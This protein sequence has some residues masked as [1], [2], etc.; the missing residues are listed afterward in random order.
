MALNNIRFVL[1]QGGLGRPLAG[2]DHI[3]GLVFYCVNGSLPSGFTTTSRIKQFFSVEDAEAAGILANYS[4]ETAAE[5]SYLVTAIG[6]NGDTVGFTVAEPLGVTVNLGT[7]TKTAAETTVNAIATAITAIINAGTNTHG[8]SA[9]ANTATVTIVARRGMGVFFNSGTPLTATASG[10]L[11]GTLTQ[12]TGGV[13]SKQAVWHYHISEY[14]RL[15]PQGNLYVGFFAVPTP[16]TFSEIQTIQNYANG[17]IRQVGLY[18]DSAAYSA[19]DVDLIHGVCNSLVAAHKEIIAVYAADMAAVTDISTLTDLSTKSDNLVSVVIGQDGAALGALL[20]L[21]TGKSITTLGATLGAISLA[22]VSESIAWLRK[23][24]ISNGVECDTLAFAN[25]KLFSD[26][27][28]TD[29]LLSALQDKCYTFLRKFVG[30]AGSF[31]NENRTAIART[32]DYAYINDNRTIQKATRGVYTSLIFDLNGPLTL[33]ADGTLAATTIASLQ[34]NS[35]V[36]LIQMIRDSE[37]SAYQVAINP[38]QNVLQTE[39]LVITINLVPIGTARNIQVNI[40]FNV[41]IN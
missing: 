3:S 7:Y 22:K 29:S 20:Y 23:F 10:T 28:V 8:Y 41:A 18:K 31:F 39:L 40:G 37:L 19:S 13:A 2:Q 17:T 11:A 12:F 26:V 14:F 6:V 24:N 32:S 9:E 27:T 34:G 33:N 1:G 38:A 16:Y 30:V 25:G 21:T 5:G 4:D 35:E 15:Q 36:N